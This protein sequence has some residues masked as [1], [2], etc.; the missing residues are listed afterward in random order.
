M[1]REGMLL[2]LAASAAMFVAAYLTDSHIQLSGQLGICLLSPNNWGIPAFWGWVLNAVL[3]A[4]SVLLLYLLNKV[5]TVVPGNDTILPGMFLLT[6]ASNVWL[7]GG[8]T[9]GWI[10]V[11]AHLLCL[12]VLFSSYRSRNAAQSLFVIATVLSL[13]SM[14]QYAFIFFIPAYLLGAALMKC[15]KF[16]P[17]IGFIL[18]LIAPYWVGVGLGIIPLSNFHTPELSNFMSTFSSKSDIFMSVA[19]MAITLLVALLLGMNNI[20]KLYAGNTQRR[21]NNMVID[22]LGVTCII[23]L[24][25]DFKNMPVYLGV[26]Y[27]IFAVQLA[28][29]FA[30]HSVRRGPL[31]LIAI[32]LIYIASFVLQIVY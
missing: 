26:C 8:L 13:G 6:A 17:F 19:N 2:A 7:S 4:I 5:H 28:N 10:M 3:A 14:I 25:F 9:S 12:G 21:L 31:V 18:G 24:L 20:V 22:L 27:M 30:L 1:G 32:A 23:C 11:M 29:C 16:K 15:L